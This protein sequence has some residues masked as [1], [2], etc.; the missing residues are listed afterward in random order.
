MNVHNPLPS[1]ARQQILID[2]YFAFVHPHFPI[3]S[4]PSFS[5]QYAYTLANPNSTEFSTSSGQGKVPIVLLLAMFSLASRYSDAPQS[6]GDAYFENACRI[7]NYDF[8]NSRLSNCQVML[9]L[10]L[11]EIGAGGMSGSW[12]YTGMAIRLAQDLGLFRDVDKW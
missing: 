2:L 9:L 6:E 3:L 1:I 12:M 8:C 4:R 5:R 7:L 11:R 10:G